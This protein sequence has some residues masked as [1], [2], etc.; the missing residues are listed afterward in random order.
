MY[1]CVKAVTPSTTA[2]SL[3]HRQGEGS[4]PRSKITSFRGTNCKM[5]KAENTNWVMTAITIFCCLS[6]SSCNRRAQ[7]SYVVTAP[8]FSLW[9]GVYSVR[10]PPASSDSSHPTRTKL[11]EEGIS[12][13]CKDAISEKQWGGTNWYNPTAS[14]QQ[15]CDSQA[16]CLLLIKSVTALSI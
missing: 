1:G 11:S 16:A 7:M 2:C 9:L 10:D 14:I 4:F 13:R 6:S 5:P 3:Q 8:S 12:R 15:R